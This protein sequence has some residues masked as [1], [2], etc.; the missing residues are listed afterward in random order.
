MIKRELAKDPKL[1]N[2]NWDRFL[3]NFTQRKKA[4]QQSSN[5]NAKGEPSTMSKPTPQSSTSQSP[6]TQ[7]ESFKANIKQQE[8]P[9]KKKYTPFPPPQLPRK[10]SGLFS[11]PTVTQPIPAPS[12]WTIICYWLQS[13]LSL[14]AIWYNRLVNNWSQVNIYSSQERRRRL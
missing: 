6:P 1:A 3:P 13:R 8:C 5:P 12:I 7:S 9:K 2:E 11:I 14:L 10:V 4:K